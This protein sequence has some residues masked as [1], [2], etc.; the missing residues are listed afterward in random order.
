MK[1]HVKTPG[2]KSIS[3]RVALMSLLYSGQVKVENIS[4]AADVCSSLEAVKLLGVSVWQ[5]EDGLLIQGANGEISEQAHIDCGN[6]GTTIRLLMGILGGLS[7]NYILDGDNSLRARPMERVAKPLR[8]MGA[9]IKTNNGKCPIQIRPAKLKGISYELPVASAQLKS[10]ILLAG[11]CADGSTTVIEPINSRD[12]TERLIKQL[13]GHIETYNN[14]ITVKRSSLKAPDRFRAPGDP[15]SAAFFLCAAAMIP[16]GNVTG[17]GVLLNPGRLGFVDV[18]MRMGADLTIEELGSDPEPWGTIRV[19]FKKGLKA[20]VIEEKEIPALVDEIPIL[21]LLA[22]Q[23]EGATEFKGVGELRVK[24]SDRLEAV[25]NCLTA[26]G[27]R[28]VVGRD[29]LIV[30]GPTD[31]RPVRELA[32]YGDHRIAMTIKIASALIGESIQMDD[33]LCINISYPEFN[34]DLNRLIK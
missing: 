14:K 18:L 21:A 1:G 5:N 2:D 9:D 32:T 25:Y 16:G 15:S 13:R 31:L 34:E 6:S 20:C 23:V 22:T 30:E 33:E 27:A 8:D 24:E 29:N 19:K 12:H 10:A 28:V 26:M 17:D 7:G 3:H 4:T 11:L